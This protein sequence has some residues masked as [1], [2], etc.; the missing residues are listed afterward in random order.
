MKAG[1]LKQRVSRGRGLD[2]AGAALG[3]GAGGA[4]GQKLGGGAKALVGRV[5]V[6]DVEDC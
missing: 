1:R 2:V 4:P 6:D 3:V 5:R